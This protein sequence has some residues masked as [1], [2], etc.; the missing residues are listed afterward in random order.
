MGI[1][2]RWRC[3]ISRPCG[4]IYGWITISEKVGRLRTS[5]S[6]ILRPGCPFKQRYHLAAHSLLDTHA[7]KCMLTALE[8]DGAHHTE[9]SVH[10]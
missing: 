4:S 7:L 10:V 1:K 6:P 5:P 2:R 8:Y 9:M 3:L